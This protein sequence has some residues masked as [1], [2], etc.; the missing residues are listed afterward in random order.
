MKA[1]FFHNM[2]AGWRNILK[3][4]TQN[5]ISVLCLS[6]G[7]LCFAIALY[8]I[9]T[10]WQNYVKEI[11]EGGKVRAYATLKADSLITETT[12]N[13]AK[14]IES[15][16]SVKSV[17]YKTGFL[18]NT[19]VTYKDA[20][21]LTTTGDNHFSFVSPQWLAEENFYSMST[22]KRVGELKPGTIILDRRDAKLLFGDE[23][24]IG[25]EVTFNGKKHI[26]S[27]VVYSPTYWGEMNGL[28]VVGSQEY[29]S[30]IKTINIE[31]LLNNGYTCDDLRIELEKKMPQL[32][33]S[34]YDFKNEDN[35][36][37]YIL[38]L[39]F[40]TFLGASVLLIGLSGFLKMQL[41]LFILRTREMAL[42]RC[43]GAKPMELFMLLCSE[44]FIIF[45]FVAVVSML[46][47][48]T[49]EAY[50]MPMLQKFQ[51]LSMLNLQ[52]S[53]IYCTELVIVV[54]AFVVS[55]IIAWMTVR[56][57]LKVSLADN[58]KTSFTQR[59]KWN[60][61]M[62]VTQY[63]VAVILFFCISLM[64]YVIYRQTSRHT[65]PEKTS[66]YKNIVSLK[67]IPEKVEDIENL[68]SV[69][70]SG[71]IFGV[72]YYVDQA[73][74]S[75]SKNVP[76]R[77]SIEKI[78]DSDST[79][80]I[81]IYEPVVADAATFKILKVK[82]RKD[83]EERYKYFDNVPVYVK[84]QKA[85][86]VMKELNV[87][88][89][90]SEEEFLLPDGNRYMMI[91]YTERFPQANIN[92]LQTGLYIVEDKD[93]FLKN[94][95]N[96][97]KDL[98][99]QNDWL[100]L[101]K[102]NDVKAFMA[103]FNDVHHKSRPDVPA[104]IKFDLPTLYDCWFGEFEVFDFIRQL[105]YILIFVS[106]LSIVLTVF[107]SIS[108]ETRG[109]QKEV[110]IRKVNGAKTRDIVMLFSRY[111]II[112]LSI[113]FVLAAIIGAISF[114]FLNWFSNISIS[115]PLFT[116][117]EFFY[118]ILLPSLFSIL[119]ISS[120]TIATVWKKIYNIAHVNPANLIKKE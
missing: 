85:A 78:E 15:M 35:A 12:Y 32:S 68:P 52:T 50:T 84:K 40:L 71:Q 11:V 103:D 29:A 18:N 86:N 72:Y 98:G 107:S 5:I 51:V 49:F 6:V 117:R 83:F 111:Y 25:Y 90:V 79:Y 106:L 38:L 37:L 104:E 48:C 45:C 105:L 63:L 116:Y 23:S 9:N 17:L 77:E 43:N 36:F 8:F 108:L 34:L 118:Y 87:S 80:K 100:I 64:F 3:Y 73:T 76:R 53:I 75:I 61:A 66:Y 81:N 54:V 99:L 58:V 102:N 26:V 22:G 41:Q 65:F 16:P 19:S 27:D 101:P 13:M 74:D 44:L 88:Y 97:Y 59:T 67:G 4:K 39:A 70:L 24:P 93:E 28:L 82:I 31:I 56:K 7:V 42:R 62:Q 94:Q 20:S 60:S 33:W 120:V 92:Y 14:Q 55:V 109:K 114:F 119:V 110:A 30:M 96:E 2:T 21:G 47:S 113:A 89:E 10:T 112:T 115:L 95:K 91:G 46:I 57:N 1:L 69:A